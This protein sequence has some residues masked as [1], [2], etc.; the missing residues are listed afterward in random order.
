MEFI[1]Q[2][3]IQSK[4]LVCHPEHGSEYGLPGKRIASYNLYLILSNKIDKK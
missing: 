3:Y 2:N 1:M 4:Q